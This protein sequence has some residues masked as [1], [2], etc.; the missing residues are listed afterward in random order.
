MSFPIVQIGFYALVD[1]WP[2]A[3]SA[4]QS[5]NE[6]SRFRLRF[7]ISVNSL[8]SLHG[9]ELTSIVACFSI[10]GGTAVA[11]WRRGPP[12]S[13]SSSTFLLKAF[14]NSST[15]GYCKSI[16]Y[17]WSTGALVSCS[18][19]TCLPMKYAFQHGKNKIV[20]V[21]R[22]LVSYQVQVHAQQD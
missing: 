2:L 12:S 3:V 20:R 8:Q 19:K 11:R 5:N 14:L 9:G 6:I 1:L 4:E 22:D 10:I 7:N 17:C 18:R 21:Y 16:V 13:D 15:F